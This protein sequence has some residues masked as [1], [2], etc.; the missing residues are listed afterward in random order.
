MIDNAGCQWAQPRDFRG[1]KCNK[2]VIRTYA[3]TV[4]KNL[5]EATV[6]KNAQS[7]LIELCDGDKEDNGYIDIG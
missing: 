7:L 3:L 2:D 1:L 4:T 5:F 6:A